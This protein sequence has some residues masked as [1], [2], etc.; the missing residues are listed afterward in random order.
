VPV[1]SIHDLPETCRDGGRHHRAGRHAVHAWGLVGG[2][3]GQRSAS[4]A[5]VRSARRLPAGGRAGGGQHRAADPSA[6]TSAHRGTVRC[7]SRSRP[8]HRRFRCHRRRRSGI[9]HPSC[10][11][12]V[13]RPGGTAIWLGLL[14]AESNVDATSWCGW[15]SG[16][17]GSFAYSDAEFAEAMSIVARWTSAGS[18]LSHLDEGA[19]RY[20]RIDE[21]QGRSR[22]SAAG[23]VS[24]M[25]VR[26]VRQSDWAA[27]RT[28]DRR[29]VRRIGHHRH[30]AAGPL[31]YGSF[32]RDGLGNDVAA[33]VTVD[34]DDT[35]VAAAVG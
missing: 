7:R 9:R 19:R 26:G 28:V 6:R 17:V 32:S 12:C 14:S 8:A 10:I 18:T 30:S 15:K 23:A 34:D 13:A 29:D 27:S 33:F 20:H 5:A 2:A 1:S 24:D 3:T 21:R 16:I 11:G 4:S 22:Q 31:I 25:R 35:P